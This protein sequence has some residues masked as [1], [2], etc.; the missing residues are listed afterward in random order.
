V[1]IVDTALAERARTG[2]PIRVAII[3][4]GFMGSRI[5]RQIGERVAGMEVVAVASRDSDDAV[6]ALAGAGY[7]DIAL[8][9]SADDVARALAGGRVVAT[10][11]PLHVATAPG[12]DV[13]V[14]A[15]GDVE[16]GAAVSIAAIRAGHH[17]VLVNADA[18]ATIGPILKVYADRAGVVITGTD[19]DEPAVAMNLIR[20]V[21]SIGYAPV[22]AGN[23]K[24]FYDPH[25]N[26]DTRRA[27]AESVGQR[28]RMITSFADGTKLSIESTLLANASG[29]RVRRRGMEG[30]KIGHVRE[31]LD[32][33][34][35]ASFA[36]CGFVDFT[37]GAEPG[38][39]AF[40]VAVGDGREDSTMQYFKMGDGPLYLFYQP[41]HLPHLEA[42]ITVA[43]AALFGDAAVTPQGAPVCEVVTLAKRD[44]PAGTVLDGIGGFD[45]YGTI[46]NANAAHR[47]DLL[48]VGL[49]A[50]CRLLREVQADSPIARTDVEP[51]GGRLV[52]RLYGEQLSHFHSAT[53]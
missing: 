29:L 38:T 17:V 30:H 8:V 21:R 52:D 18:D 31:L 44:L 1:I 42:P 37:L 27:F 36:E 5:A 49:A 4:A 32:V 10:S 19:G 26:P 25:R 2:N 15:T 23:M 43:R 34:D 50:G 13:I 46:D 6:A 22:L 16:C 33:L 20:H 45:C 9:D 12:I 53:N 28:P 51:P 39:G 41:Y 14:E 3:G 7:D 48:P 35:P 11:S 24:G 40:V 47:A